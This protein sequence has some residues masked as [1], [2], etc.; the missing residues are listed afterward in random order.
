MNCSAELC[1]QSNPVFNH[2]QEAGCLGLTADPCGLSLSVVE[3]KADNHR[4]SA[5]QLTLRRN[6]RVEINSLSSQKKGLVVDDL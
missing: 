5:A 3:Q 6:R 4:S 1:K 2:S